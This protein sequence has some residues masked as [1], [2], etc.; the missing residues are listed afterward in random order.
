MKNILVSFK[1]IG[2]CIMVLVFFSSCVQK[3]EN[4][5]ILVKNTLDFDRDELI[6]IPYSGFSQM[7]DADVKEFKIVN[8]KN[9]KEYPYQLESLGENEPQNILIQVNIPANEEIQLVIKARRADSIA[10]KTFGRY[11]PERFDDFAWE[12]DVVAFRMYG[13]ALEGREDDA[14]GMDIWAKRTNNLI[15]DKWYKSEDYHEDHGEGLDYYSVGQTLGAG[16]IAPYSNGVLHYSKHYRTYQVLD[17]GPLRTT[18]RLNF[19]PWKVGEANVKMSKTVSIDAGSQLNK[20]ELDFDIEG[21]EE[22]TIAAGIAKRKDEGEVLDKHK[23]GIFGYWEPQYEENGIIGVGLVFDKPVDSVIVDDGQF[24]SLFQVE[25]ETPV[26]YH[27]GGAWNKAG[28]IQSASAWLMYLEQ[29][30]EGLK[31]PL[32]VKIN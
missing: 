15:I 24:L 29:Y 9:G 6:S 32:E 11:V 13:K 4:K 31:N 25:S 2:K 16:D 12:N 28:R 20:I 14:Q 7:L 22:L 18:F 1:Y 8:K 3:S 17:N 5:E 27:S 21:K 23:D 26:V 19:E 30:K 10:S